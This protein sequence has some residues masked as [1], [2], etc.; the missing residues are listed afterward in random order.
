[1][2]KKKGK[3]KKWNNPKYGMLGFARNNYWEYLGI[4]N[5]NDEVTVRLGKLV[6]RMERADRTVYWNRICLFSF[7]FKKKKKNI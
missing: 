5:D 4:M 2:L 1:L 6:E 3:R 7:F